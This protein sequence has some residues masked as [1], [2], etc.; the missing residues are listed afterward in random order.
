MLKLLK[1]GK[2][3]LY[4]HQLFLQSAPH[5]R[6]R[7]QTIPTQVQKSSNL[8][9]LE[10]QALHAADKGQRFYVGLCISPEASLRPRRPREQAVAFVE[11]NRVN[12]KPN[13]L[14]D[15]ANLHCLGSS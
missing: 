11:A 1:V 9:E 8:T 12:A 6:A 2:F 15:D 4:I 7:L 10:A 13:L 3:P 14:R 5:R